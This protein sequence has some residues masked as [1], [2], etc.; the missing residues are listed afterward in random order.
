MSRV[1]KIGFILIN[2]FSK[3]PPFPFIL[4]I[5]ILLFTTDN[6]ES[7]YQEA[8]DS[9]ESLKIS[10]EEHHRL[11]WEVHRREIEVAEL[12]QALSDAQTQLFDERKQL[13]KVIADNDELKSNVIA[14]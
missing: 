8:L 1:F 11:S 14:L 2:L 3:E 12:Q 7:E 10:H 9:V 6:V 5:L 4:Q 13:L